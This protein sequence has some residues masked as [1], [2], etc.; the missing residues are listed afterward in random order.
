[1][2]NFTG[3]LPSELGNLTKLEQM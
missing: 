2:N 3:E 1:L